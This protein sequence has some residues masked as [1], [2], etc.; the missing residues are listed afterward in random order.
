MSHDRR[1]ARERRGATLILMTVLMTV[2]I[3]MAAFALDFGR[4]Y[5][6]RSQL[7]NAADA[8]SW[9]GIQRLKI[10]DDPVGALDT[11]FVYGMWHRVATGTAARAW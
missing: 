7:Q 2:F 9:A 6:Y 10:N 5:M 4:F 1:M 3:G 11:A 8:A